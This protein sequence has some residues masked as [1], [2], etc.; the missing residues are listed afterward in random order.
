MQEKAY[1]A[2]NLLESHLVSEEEKEA[3][4]ERIPRSRKTSEMTVR[5][6]L[7]AYYNLQP[8]AIQRMFKQSYIQN[9]QK[10]M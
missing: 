6:A 9:V 2:T 8:A 3:I 5:D 10:M 4:E 7:W 1:Q